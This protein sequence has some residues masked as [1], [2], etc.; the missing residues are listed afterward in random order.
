MMRKQFIGITWQVFLCLTL[1]LLTATS[2]FEFFFRLRLPYNETGRYFDENNSVVFHDDAIPVFGGLFSFSLIA[3]IVVILRG[4][5]NYC[6]KK[7]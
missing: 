1:L 6:S 5:K 3:L 2:G 7:D 4:C